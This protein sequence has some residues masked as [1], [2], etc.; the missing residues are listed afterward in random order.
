M[1]NSVTPFFHRADGEC[2]AVVICMSGTGSNAE[3][4]LK[5]IS[6]KIA[7]FR[8]AVI[9]TDNPDCA[10]SRLGK[11]FNV[12]VECLDIRKF[13]S[14]NGEENIKLDSDRKRELRE[15]WSEKVWQILQPYQVDFAIF[16][17]FIPL[18]SLPEKLPCLNVHPGDLTIET[19]GKRRYVGLHYKPVELA[20]TDGR[21]YLRSSVIIVQ[22]L[23]DGGAK[24]VDSGPLLGVSAPVAVDLE[25]KSAEQLKNIAASRTAPPYKDCLRQIAE[26]NIETLKR[27]GDHVVLP[28]V[29][30]VFA[31]GKYGYDENGN[32]YLADDSGKWNPIKTVEYAPDGSSK[33]IAP[34]K[35]QKRSRNFLMRYL[36]Y[37]YV[38]IIRTDG[39]PDYAARGWALGMFIGCVVPIFCQLI[40]AIPLSFVI[41]GSKI[42]A[43]LG[44]FITTPVTAPFIYPVVIWVG[45]KVV[46]G[47]LS[48]EA[49]QKLL[50]VF[51][52]PALSF[53]EKWGA[54]ADL[55]ADLAIAF[56]AG[57]LL[58]AAIMTPLTYFGV[59]Y[60]VIRYRKIRE[61][62][63]NKARKTA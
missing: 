38:K 10:A 34:E 50:D 22:S 48:A 51:N 13:Y 28:A 43:A 36:K 62:I 39:S 24:E 44:T 9:F 4:L 18:N 5:S 26:K 47:N 27:S 60:L 33:I 25:G 41:R 31:E 46:R 30:A 20:L 63:R 37:L 15:Q 2:P 16:A 7:S 55:G 40:I 6:G 3:V 56:F 61:K 11:E 58:W 17:G 12:P 42:G 21:K 8:V 35:K 1:S 32:L 29:T 23:K 53:T 59:R 14:D 52:D 57:G 54:F 49:S 19:D 45:N